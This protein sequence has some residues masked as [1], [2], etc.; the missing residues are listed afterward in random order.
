MHLWVR[1]GGCSFNHDGW[2][3]PVTVYC[4]EVLLQFLHCLVEVLGCSWLKIKHIAFQ[5]SA[6]P[7]EVNLGFR[8][9]AW[10]IL[11]FLA[12]TLLGIGG[13]PLSPVSQYI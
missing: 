6:L 12:S 9:R 11:R 4:S 8:I 3:V 7:L 10:F 1:V 13:L 2:L 5:V